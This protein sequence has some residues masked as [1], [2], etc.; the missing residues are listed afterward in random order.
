MGRVRR[1]GGTGRQVSGVGRQVTGTGEG[2]REVGDT[3]ARETGEG[4]R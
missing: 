2:D 3:G 1:D 4:D